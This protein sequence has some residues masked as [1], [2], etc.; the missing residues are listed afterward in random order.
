MSCLVVK[1]TRLG[2]NCCNPS[3]S[4]E[5]KSKEKLFFLIFIYFFDFRF[6]H[7]FRKKLISFKNKIEKK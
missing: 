5:K 1:S 2:F 7:L 6:L 3:E 4:T